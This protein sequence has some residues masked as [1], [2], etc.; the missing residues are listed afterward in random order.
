M[1]ENIILINCPRCKTNVIFVSDDACACDCRNISSFLKKSTMDFYCLLYI[2]SYT[3]TLS[4]DYIEIDDF[5]NR[6]LLNCYFN[7]K[8]FNI[9]IEMQDLF[10]Q[11]IN[12]TLKK[13]TKMLNIL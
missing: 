3:I 8:P 10:K 12:S 13:L 4:H 2:N 7:N 6:A 11:N 1:I 5:N 9:N